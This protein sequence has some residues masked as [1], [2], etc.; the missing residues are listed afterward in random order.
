M[1][2]WEKPCLDGKVTVGQKISEHAH[3][4]QMDKRYICLRRTIGDSQQAGSTSQHAI[5][6]D[7]STWPAV[8]FLQRQDFVSLLHDNPTAKEIYAT[9]TSVKHI[10]HRIRK[11]AQKFERYQHNRDL[12][13]LVNAFAD[14]TQVLPPG[15]QMKQESNGKILFIDHNRRRTTFIDPRLPTV[16]LTTSARTTRR[17]RALSA[18]PTHG[19][20]Y[21][22]TDEYHRRVIQFLRQPTFDNL[23]NERLPTM[24]QDERLRKKLA[25]IAK[26]GLTA[27]HKLAND[28]DVITVLS[29][30][31][32]E[33]SGDSREGGEENGKE[34][35]AFEKKLSNFYETLRSRGYAQGPGKIKL[36]LRR[37]HL[38][39]DA[40]EQVS[41]AHKRDLQR[42][43]IC[44]AFDDEDG[45]DY[46][47]P[48][49]EFFFLL[50]R[51]LFN[52]YYGLFEYSA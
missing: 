16:V 39:T 44:I 24:A 23:L 28:I 3:R 9:S 31:E 22:S 32:S 6:N 18:P 34:R 5:A 17:R 2:C 19:R 27:L 45:L 52:P 46:G 15:W 38:L 10:I 51:D 20:N 48:S 36:T 11:D 35:D 41:A 13:A 30:F 21:S 43:R 26:Q 47:G 49:R 50:S 1:T 33:I 8:C 40:F 12:V 37:K 7:E 14:Q 4:R 25:T 29:L 42:N